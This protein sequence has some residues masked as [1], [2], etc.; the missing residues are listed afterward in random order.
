MYKIRDFVY[1]SDKRKKNRGRLFRWAGEG[2]EKK[3]SYSDA[4]SETQPNG[5]TTH[6]HRD[7]CV[8]ICRQKKK[9]RGLDKRVGRATASGNFD[10][11]G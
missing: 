9:G 11:I 10:E 8:R 2:R 4:Q 7:P 5:R 1:C 3:Q 6:S